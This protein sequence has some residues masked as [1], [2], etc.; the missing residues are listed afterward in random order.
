[1][2]DYTLFLGLQADCSY[3]YLLH[4][5]QFK[6]K[7]LSFPSLRV[8]LTTQYHPDIAVLQEV[9][10]PAVLDESLDI[11]ERER[12]AGLV[13]QGIA[14]V[15]VGKGVCVLQQDWLD[16]LA[17]MYGWEKTLILWYSDQGW[18]LSAASEYQEY[19]GLQD[20]V[21]SPVPV[22]EWPLGLGPAHTSLSVPIP[23]IV[24]YASHLPQYLR[25]LE[26][27]EKI[28]VQRGNGVCDAMQRQIATA[29]ERLQAVSEQQLNGNIQR[30]R[31]YQAR[32][33]KM[34]SALS[35]SAFQPAPAVSESDIARVS[36]LKSRI[37]NLTATMQT[38]ATQLAQQPPPRSNPYPLQ[39][40][41]AKAVGFHLR[42][43]IANF[44]PFISPVFYQ[45]EGQENAGGT[46]PEGIQAGI[47][48]I[49]L[50]KVL[51]GRESLA[52]SLWSL[53]NG[54]YIRISQSIS[55]TVAKVETAPKLLP[56]PPEV[57]SEADTSA[58]SSLDL[59][60]Y[61]GMRVEGDLRR[62]W[63]PISPQGMVWAS[64]TLATPQLMPSNQD[65]FAA[66]A[67]SEAQL[68][69]PDART[70]AQEYP[71]FQMNTV[72]PQLFP[73]FDPFQT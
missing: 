9:F 37:A 52:I 55:V 39:I 40:C 70:F 18:A 71:L 43:I 7:G 8:T 30:I 35:P 27:L 12:D 67:Y 2:A 24:E 33:E 62:P 56:L 3:P 64:S 57:P 5:L 59:V 63:A 15:H 54:D 53:M 58:Q 1:M 68:F 4:Y 49:L 36:S 14:Q 25:L 47:Q 19:I 61:D 20:P 69:H 44:K 50:E 34:K 11:L 32:Y 21:P 65:Q 26:E 22:P 46:I 73:L 38:K 23:Q 42:L 31:E 6:C 16:S 28:A 60:G 10:G 48:I 72:P 13:A 17:Q 41:Q 51:L 29:M 66:L 45:I